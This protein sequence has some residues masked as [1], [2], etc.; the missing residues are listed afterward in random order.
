MTN[1]NLSDTKDAQPG[2]RAG[3]AKSGAPLNLTLYAVPSRTI[4][5]RQ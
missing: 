2:V 3:R 4:D 5:D 1:P